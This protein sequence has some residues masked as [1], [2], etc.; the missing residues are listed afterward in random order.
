MTL[1]TKF[2]QI[3]PL[4][5][6]IAIS[7]SLIAI[8]L[9]SETVLGRWDALLAG[10]DFD[11]LARGSDGILRDLRLAIVHCLLAGYLP[12]ALLHVV[13]RGRRTVLVL[14]D[15]LNCTREECERLAASVRLSRRGLLITGVLGIALAFLTPYMVPPCHRPSGARRA[16]A[17]KSRGT[18]YSAR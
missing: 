12:A 11:P 8:L 5:F 2:E 3:S 1:R 10:G 9:V 18:A 16:G 7:G 15:A 17:P 14:Q 4:W 6:G 13:Q